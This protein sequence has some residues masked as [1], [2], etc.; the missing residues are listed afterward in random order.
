MKHEYTCES[1]LW[2]DMLYQRDLT[3]AGERER[4]D[5]E[6]HTN[7]ET[8]TVVMLLFETHTVLLLL[9]V[10]WFFMRYP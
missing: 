5:D 4:E 2:S 3:C 8:H 9:K 7:S 10:T 6:T 1:A